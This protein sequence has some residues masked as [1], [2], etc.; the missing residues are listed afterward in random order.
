[1]DDVDGAR[2]KFV[3][4][5]KTRESNKVNDIEGASPKIRKNR[6]MFGGYNNLNYADVTA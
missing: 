1:V 5:L 4:D 3:R 2:P 6:K